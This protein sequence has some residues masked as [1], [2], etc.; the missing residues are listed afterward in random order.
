M[1]KHKKSLLIVLF[2]ALLLLA[3]APQFKTYFTQEQLSRGEARGVLIDAYG[4]LRLA[5]AAQELFRAT[6]PYVWCAA[7]ARGEVYIGGGNPALVLRVQA[8]RADTVFTSAEVA[9]FALAQLNGDLFIA[10]SP[11]GQ[12]Y[13]RSANQK[14]RTFFKP[15]AKYIWAMEPGK[16]GTLFVATGEPARIYQVSPSGEARVFFESEEKHLRSLCWDGRNQILYAGSSG[17]GY[18][19]RLQRDGSVTVMYDAPLDEIHR[20]LLSPA[21]AIYA[22]AAGGGAFF[23]AFPGT[24]PGA[25]PAVASGG[26]VT[27]S[28]T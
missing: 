28:L 3:A 20:I 10:T 7:E 24:A 27:F 13:R 14:A 12:I 17:N 15:E 9:V 6:I 4:R 8:Q 1:Q 25:A 23:P 26:A 16:D 5:P 18:I 11:D 22:A 2:P 21:G 19:Y